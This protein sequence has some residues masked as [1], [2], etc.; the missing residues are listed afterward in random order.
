MVGLALM[1]AARSFV[2]SSWIE[3][4]YEETE[5][6]SSINLLL[7][8]RILVGLT[9]YMLLFNAGWIPIDYH[10]YPNSLSRNLCYTGLG[11]VLLWLAG[12]LLQNVMFEPE[13]IEDEEEASLLLDI[14]NDHVSHELLSG[15]GFLINHN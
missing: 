1:F 15:G 10:L 4:E 9:G 5:K 12:S 6:H 7:S 13:I 8:I 2:S 3:T 11:M 14:E